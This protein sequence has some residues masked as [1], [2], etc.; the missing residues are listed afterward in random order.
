LWIIQVHLIVD[1]NNGKFD[2]FEFLFDFCFTCAEQ[3]KDVK[4]SWWSFL[5]PAGLLEIFEQVIRLH[6]QFF[7]EQQNWLRAENW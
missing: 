6:F 2:Q 3:I 5:G 4:W 1:I 7:A